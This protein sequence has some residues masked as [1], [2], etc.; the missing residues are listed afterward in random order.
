MKK[1]ALLLVFTFFT[2]LFAKQEF[3]EPKP[4]F[5]NPRRWMVR[6]YDPEI[7]KVNHIISSVYNVLKEYPAETLNIVILVYGPGM[8]VLKKDYNSLILTRIKSLMEYDVEFIA[9]KNTMQTM[10]WT[11]KDLIDNLSYVQAG[12]AESIERKVGGW[13]EVTPY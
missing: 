7:H 1:I 10:G 12:I 6:I 2:L 3:N 4:T 8:R 11:K 5:D 13:I 9:C